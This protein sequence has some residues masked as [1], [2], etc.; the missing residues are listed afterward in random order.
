MTRIA[1]DPV[2]RI[3]GH[4][5]IEAEVSGGVV[6]DA[7][8]SAT[9]FRGLELVLRGRDPRDAWLF[10]QRICG[11]CTGVQALAS[12][13][14]VEHALG[15]TVPRN[16][17]LVR[18][19]MAGTQYLLDH[20]LHFYHQHALDWVDV[21]SARRAD[22]AATST[23]AL[24]T[25]GWPHSSTSHFRDARD[26]LER[27][28]ASGQLGP[29]ANGPW[30]H[31]AYRLSAEANLLVVAHYL[32][33]LDWQRAIAQIHTIL[34]GK[35]PHPQTFLVGGMA[36]APPWGGPNRG[37]PG[38]HPQQIDKRAPAA[39][40]EASLAEIAELLAAAKSFVDQVYV[41]DVLLVAGHYPEW[42]AIGAGIG[43]YLSYGEFPADD[44]PEPAL[45]LPR[46]RVMGRVMARVGGVDQAA[47]TETVTHAWYTY[48]GDPD[49]LR[50]PLE[51][52]TNARYAGP[53]LPY[54]T[55][56]GS[57]KYSWLKAPRY[58]DEPMEV[59]PLA[60]ILV[61]YVEG[62]TEVRAAVQRAV[63]ALGVGPEALFST[64]G[65]MVARAVE[66]EVIASQL[67]TWHRELTGSLADG[68]LAFADLG[69]WEPG[70]WP[71]EARGWSLGEAPGGA[72]GHWVTIRDRTIE[73]YQI[74]DAS[75]WNGS[76]RDGKG[77]RGAWE[78]ALVGTP[79][80]D[81]ERPLEILR[82]L[83]SFDPCTACGVHAF[84]PDDPGPLQVRIT[85][86]V[87]R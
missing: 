70:S 59:G 11:S 38:E 16:A 58:Q 50:N 18:N 72:L 25:S 75:T 17:R 26:R 63:T 80:A 78:E 85:R 19:I 20:V 9:M 69:R 37:L 12:V 79:V 22:P 60:R 64:L 5:R 30:G 2:T 51:G 68:D 52:Q 71:Q 7:W 32:E 8:S 86:R 34:G 1:I 73:G 67:G 77:R 48:D 29:F 81:P 54:A 76:P 46:G 61:A 15:A 4:L 10:A 87:A 36:L 42:A 41:P 53:P 84:D 24:A 49:G 44:T 28:L 14:A 47:V 45:F 21:E 33:A 55:L 31:P 40:S 74:V 83:R 57:E 39:L 23:L 6:A 62:R 43:N 56:A 13:R 82:T 35:N 65:R 66:A 27:F 3:G